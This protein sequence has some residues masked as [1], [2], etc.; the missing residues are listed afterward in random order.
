MRNRE[1]NIKLG[2]IFGFLILI[3]TGCA[4]VKPKEN[5]L[6]VWHWM[7]DRRNAFDELAK[8]YKQET[9]QD[10]EFKL[11]F[12]PEIYSQKVIAAARAKILPD[13]F[14]ILGE[15]KTL[16]SFIKAGYI[17]NLASYMSEKREKEKNRQW[18]DSFYPQ[19]LKVVTFSEKNNYDISAG[20]YGVPIDT[21]IMQF[22]YNKTL[23]RKAGLDPN[24]SPETVSDFINQ[25]QV[26]KEKLG[27]SGFICGWGEGW[28]LNALA[29]EW[30]INTMGEGKFLKTIEGEVLYT[31]PD[32]IKV[33]S[34][35][36]KLKDS[37]ILASNIATM[38]NKEAE[39]AFAQDKAAFSFN[40]S[41]SV[42]VYKQL[43]PELDY[44]FFSLPK[45]SGKHPVKVWG[46]AGS[47]FMVDAKSLNKEKAVDFLEWL[48]AK[49]Q[50]TFL[51]KETNNLPAIKGI[52]EELPPMLKSLLGALENLT[53]PD[54]WPKNEDSRVIEI[55][56]RSLQQIVMGLKTPQEAARQIQRKKEKVSPR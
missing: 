29:T 34:L 31:D 52:E 5:K 32:W 17:L 12:P 30:A 46:G 55:M 56:N 8:R 42:N 50:Q 54:I 37:G 28:L 36:A 47:S 21:T 11:F 44:A 6:I 39:A 40:G 22:I 2:L 9:G 15:R 51:A 27:L 45:A 41:W 26:I 38:T 10:V 3:L 7:T 13:I 1:K 49:K 24:K 25:A 48:S 43:C 4:P 35:F 16:A 18:K 20:I 14:G 19:T 23:F 33:F 53:H